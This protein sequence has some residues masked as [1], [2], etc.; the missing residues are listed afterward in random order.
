[1]SLFKP[2]WPVPDGVGCFCTT[3]KDGASRAPWNGFNLAIHVDD[4]LSDVLKNRAALLKKGQI[5]SEP[6]WLKQSHSTVVVRLDK[7]SKRHADASITKQKEQVAV[8]L[9]ADCLPLLVCNRQGDEVAAIHAGWKG[10][11]D[12]IIIKTINAMQAKP[13]ALM[14]WLGPAISQQHFAI[15]AGLKQQFCQSYPN[16]EQYFKPYND[17]YLADLY[18]L[19]KYQLNQLGVSAVYGAAFCSYAEQ[20]KFYS[21]R[22]DGVT[23]RMASLIW[24]KN[25]S[26]NS[27]QC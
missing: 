27:I 18:A 5:P 15:G 26:L 25:E 16:V 11:L 8:V 3:R 7:S 1:M 21:Y 20:D 4:C 2:I 19:A 12:G 13:N 10:L 9:S 6:Q 14:V 17:K 24:I 23:G 22:R